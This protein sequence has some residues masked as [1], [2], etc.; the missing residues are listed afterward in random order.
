MTADQNL[1]IEILKQ[2]LPPK[3][4]AN[5]DNIFV[6]KKD[7]PLESKQKVQAQKQRRTKS[8]TT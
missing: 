8:K 4:R 3:L 7:S 2:R 5:F 1:E 6:D